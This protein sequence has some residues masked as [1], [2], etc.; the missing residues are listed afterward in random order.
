MTER[1]HKP[2]P[3][4]VLMETRFGNVLMK[5]VGKNSVFVDH[6]RGDAAITIRG[7]VYTVFSG[8]FYLQDDGRWMDKAPEGHVNSFSMRRENFTDASHAARQT[9][10]L[11]LSGIVAK[12]A[13]AHPEAFREAE[14]ANISNDLRYVEKDIAEA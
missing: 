14:L 8:H 2:Y 1:E 13:E 7:V 4:A 11:E 12:Y 3:D 10:A 6:P 5:A 9:A